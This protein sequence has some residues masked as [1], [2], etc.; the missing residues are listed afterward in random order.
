[1]KAVAK[2]ICLALLLSNTTGCVALIGG[3][4]ANNALERHDD[5]K[6]LQERN[7]HQERMRELQLQERLQDKQY[8]QVQTGGDAG[9]VRDNPF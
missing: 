2:L 9:I 5:R 6:T 8:P 4:V 3:V 7:R 1:M